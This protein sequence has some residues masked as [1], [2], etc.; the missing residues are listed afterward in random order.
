MQGARRRRRPKQ[1]WKR[2]VLEKAGKCNTTC[3]EV[4]RLR[5]TESDGDASQMPYV[6]NGTK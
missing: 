6:A 5:A 3:S 2:I 1:T 4:T